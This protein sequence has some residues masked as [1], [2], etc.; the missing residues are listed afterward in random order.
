M[1][2]KSKKFIKKKVNIYIVIVSFL[3]SILILRLGWLQLVQAEL[4]QT[5]ALE[6]RVRLMP[7]QAPRGNI[8]TNDGVVLATDYPTYQVSLT[9]TPDASNID[10]VKN[11]AELLDDPELN[12]EDI[13][14]LLEEKNTRLYE[15]IIIKRDIPIESVMKLESHRSEL[16]GIIIDIAPKR[17]Y[18][19]DDLAG[20]TVGFIGELNEEELEKEGFENYKLGDFIGKTGVEKEYDEYIRG[21]EG[22]RQVEVD[23]KNRPINEITTVSPVAGNN[24][25]LTIDYDIQKALDDSFDSVLAS[26]QKQA[27][28][29]K[30]DG[31]AAVLL[32]IKSG[33]VLA[34]TTRPNDK[35]RIQNK[36]IQ[37]RY[38]PGS[39]LKMITGMAALEQGI[40]INETV[41]CTGK[42]WIKPYIGCTGVHGNISYHDAIA[43]S[44]NVYFQE[45]GRRATVNNFAEMGKEMGLDKPTGIDLPFESLGDSPFQGL[46]TNE[47]RNQYFEWAK[48]VTDQTHSKK[49][50]E[51]EKE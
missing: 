20:H 28:S 47:K 39:T 32:D 3:F 13:N 44:C 29:R 46:P 25:V 9:Y 2:I 40:G 43:R 27:R 6:N 11:L 22:F 12:E 10:V 38:I 15:P 45:M 17:T 26:L 34:M 36:A 33:K 51:A 1:N 31:G 14:A 41:R 16:P 42:Y 5:R 8:M 23:A 21:K 35:V 50:E 30:A 37:G 24:I 19:Y 48:K 4:Y 7:I 49:I 18:L